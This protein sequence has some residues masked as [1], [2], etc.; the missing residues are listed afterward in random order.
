MHLEQN[1]LSNLSITRTK[2]L[3][4][5]HDIFYCFNLL[6]SIRN[7][8]FSS[9]WGQEGT[10]MNI[11]LLLQGL[12]FRIFQSYFEMDRNL[13][14]RKCTANLQTKN[15]RF[16]CKLLFWASLS[17]TK[18]EL[19]PAMI[20]TVLKVLHRSMVQ[21]MCKNVNYKYWQE[22]KFP[23]IFFERQKKSNKDY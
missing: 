7:I 15:V 14:L 19:I 6:D 1:T 4:I 13:N 18:F 3:M 21:D 12:N 20:W 5:S 9:F 11:R 2:I 8:I 17:G 23:I 10:I 16:F 22:K